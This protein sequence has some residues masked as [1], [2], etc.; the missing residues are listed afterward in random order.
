M[1]NINNLLVLKHESKAC[2]L[3]TFVRIIEMCT[4]HSPT[5]LTAVLCC[6]CSYSEY[7][8]VNNRHQTARHVYLLPSVPRPCSSTLDWAI[9][10]HYTA[11]SLGTS[12]SMI[13]MQQDEYPNAS[14]T[15]SVACSWYRK[16]SLLKLLVRYEE[17]LVRDHVGTC[18]ILLYI[19]GKYAL[20]LSLSLPL[21]H[22]TQ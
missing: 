19:M 4:S 18:S 13:N 11:V 3:F 12:A 1:G 21:S 22:A 5:L 15:N 8:E 9:E 14:P 16:K 6:T 2:V 20:S 7:S 17:H 10:R